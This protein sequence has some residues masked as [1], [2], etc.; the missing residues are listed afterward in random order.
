MSAAKRASIYKLCG[1]PLG[2]EYIIMS[3][4]Y[5]RNSINEIARAVQKKTFQEKKGWKGKWFFQS[6]CT[7]S[8]AGKWITIYNAFKLPNQSSLKYCFIYQLYYNPSKL[9]FVASKVMECLRFGKSFD[10]FYFTIRYLESLHF[11]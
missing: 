1:I 8:N 11:D 2:M 10:C 3:S 6:F 9:Y 4:R 5:P 7:S